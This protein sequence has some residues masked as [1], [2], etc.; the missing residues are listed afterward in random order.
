MFTRS[1]C[2]RSRNLNSR[3]DGD[4]LGSS[5]GHQIHIAPH[6]F[7]DA[8]AFY[9]RSDRGIFFGYFAGANGK[10]VYTC[11]AHDVVAHETTHAL[12]DG[13]RWRY[14]EPS[15]PDQAGFH[16]GFA[17]VVALLSVFSLPDVVDACL[18]LASGG[19]GHLIPSSLLTEKVLKE[20][21]L[22]ALAEE[23]GSE[24]SA[25]RG[26]ALRRSVKLP[27]GKPYMS[28][29]RCPEFAEAHRRGELLVAAFMNSFLAIWLAR[30]DKIGPIAKGK[31]DRSIVRDEGA[32]SAGHLLTMAIRA[33]DYCPP[34]DITFSDY[35]SALLTVD[36]E[37]VPDD[38]E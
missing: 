36:R 17:D 6:A 13:L 2:A 8:N 22:F 18:D 9:S 1:P 30:I 5:D 26:E 20:S 31:K 15:M 23:M 34:T 7:A 10:V 37:V 32:Q 14:M 3:W 16:E 38:G 35:L 19:R 12:L 25:V 4:A 24:L 28:A 33:I 11:L 29:E 21:A 27:P